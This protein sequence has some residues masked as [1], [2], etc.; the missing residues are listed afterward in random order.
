MFW[1]YSWSWILRLVS[2]GDH[3]VH[4]MPASSSLSVALSL[5]LLVRGRRGLVQMLLYVLEKGPKDKN[6]NNK[7]AQ[8]WEISAELRDLATCWKKRDMRST[9]MRFWPSVRSRCLGIGQALSCV[10]ASLRF[11]NRPMRS[12]GQ[13]RKKELG[14]YCSSSHNISTLKIPYA[15][16]LLFQELL[17][18]NIVPRLS[19]KHYTDEWDIFFLKFYWL[20]EPRMLRYWVQ[21]Y[22]HCESEFINMV[23]LVLFLFTIGNLS[24]K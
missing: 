16:K 6:D 3:N 21:R 13:K 23:Q 7:N 1:C 9:Y 2:F 18:M 24:E 10:S 17:S 8:P 5:G 20:Q 11:F 14:H 22:S 4:K 12:R 19:L 15:C